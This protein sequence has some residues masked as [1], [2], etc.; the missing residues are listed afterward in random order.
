MFNLL[1]PHAF[2]DKTFSNISNN[3]VWV[4]LFFI[5]LVTFEVKNLNN[6]FLIQKWY[7]VLINGFSLT[8]GLISF[9]LNPTFPYPG[10]DFAVILFLFNVWF[11]CFID[12]FSMFLPNF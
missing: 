3:Y 2:K 10:Y 8:N 5:Y 11:A 1:N 4:V 9:F 6:V 7:H 12:I